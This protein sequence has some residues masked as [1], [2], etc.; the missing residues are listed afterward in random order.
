[1]ILRDHNTEHLSEYYTYWL[2]PFEAPDKVQV[3]DS[4]YKEG[5]FKHW[6][7]HK[8]LSLGDARKRLWV[9][10]VVTN[11]CDI[12][13]RFV[14]SI[15][16]FLDTATL[17]MSTDSGFSKISSATYWD[18]S[19]R[20]AFPARPLCLPFIV[21]NK[22]T[23]ILYLCINQHNNNLY[24]PLKIRNAVDFMQEE[25]HFLIDRHWF[26]LV[27]FYIFSIVFNLIL[28]SFL[29]DKIYLWYCL[30]VL[31]NTV[32]LLMEDSLDGLILP[33]WLFS[34]IWHAGQY[35]F[36]LLSTATGIKIMQSFTEQKKKQPA[37]YHS[38]TVIIA[39]SF[40]FGLFIFITQNYLSQ[41]ASARLINFIKTGRDILIFVNLFFILF[42]LISGF[43]RRNTLAYYYGVTYFFFFVSCMMFMGNHLGI[44]SI[45][46]VE[47][48]ILAWGLLL[49]L[50]TLSLLLTGRFRFIIK[51]S[52][53]L[54]IQ[55]IEL[56]K[57]QVQKLL[58]TQEAERKRLAEDLH[59]QVGP[60]I[61]ALTLHISNLSPEM[62]NGSPVMEKYFRQALFLASRANTDIRDISHNLLPK[63][64]TE[65]GLFRVLQN[66]IEEL[67]SMQPIRFSFI[68]MGE[69]QWLSSIYAITIYRIINELLQNIVRHSQASESVVQVLISETETEVLTEDNGIGLQNAIDK[70]GIGL[71]NI[72][73]RVAFLK[74]TINID[75][76]SKGTSTIINIPRETHGKYT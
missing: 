62:I 42:S 12:N 55:N 37:L 28:F 57:S 20:R 44:T 33:Q 56:E 58:E 34:F 73:S 41:Q 38:G 45:N 1:M 16:D 5:A 74:G 39:V 63:D 24:F 7:W 8:S 29:R 76:S 13:T 59:D 35:T 31:L 2:Q 50:I 40:L 71:K 67:N 9:R 53:E 19:S 18:I 25:Q 64:F 61:S 47:P 27:G 23:R 26:W 21:R 15:H 14:W 52:S 6:K 17:Y 4:M 72:Q 65:L 22:E 43:Y 30:Y 70:K 60:T 69:E 32:F 11:E 51:Q 46:L 75:S 10:M 48:N 36:L 3:A 68:S 54:Q 66:R 49:E